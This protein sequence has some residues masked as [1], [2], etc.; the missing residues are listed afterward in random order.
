MKYLLLL[1]RKIPLL[2]LGLVVL[3]YVYLK[4][5]FFALLVL[6]VFLCFILPLD[7]K[8]KPAIYTIF[9]IIVLL[10]LGFRAIS[11]VQIIDEYI[12]DFLNSVKSEQM[13]IN[14]IDLFGLNPNDKNIIE[15]LLFLCTVFYIT[16]K[17]QQCEIFSPL[18]YNEKFKSIFS[19]FPI[20]FT[21]DVI[22]NPEHSL[23]LTSPGATFKEQVEYT[24]RRIGLIDTNHKGWLLIV[25]IISFIV[26]YVNWSKWIQDESNSNASISISFIFVL[27]IQAVFTALCY[28]CSVSSSRCILFILNIIMFIYT[29]LI[30]F[31]YLPTCNR[32]TFSTLRF[33]FLCRFYS[34]L[35]IAHQIFVGRTICSF[36]F[37]NFTKEWRSIIVINKFIHRFPYVFEIQTIFLWMSKKTYVSLTDFF[38]IRNINLQLEILIAKQTSKNTDNK[39]PKKKSNFLTGILI[40]LVA[41]VIILIVQFLFSSDSSAGQSNPPI[42]VKLEIG[43]STFPALF[44]SQGTITPITTNQRNSLKNLKIH[45]SKTFSQVSVDTLSIIDFHYYLHQIGFLKVKY[46][47]RF[48]NY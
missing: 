48:L 20:Q 31:I 13:K 16:D 40:F 39:P 15:I 34:H 25:D 10:L 43:I 8:G 24:T 11:T 7:V 28:Y 35:I 9:F 23:A 14:I 38:I 4:P 29:Y 47:K 3:V 44:V 12:Y 27:L 45:N 36:N 37:P 46:F 42:T 18:Y 30:C 19:N 2:L 33:Y 32:K 6:L 1:F 17:L 21:Y 26:L 5:Y 41:I 22:N